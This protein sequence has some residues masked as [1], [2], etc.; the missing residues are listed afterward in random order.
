MN[1]PV[2]TTKPPAPASSPPDKGPH[3]TPL[4]NRQ[5]VKT[6]LLDLAKSKRAHKWTRVSETTL[7]TINELVRAWCVHHV[8]RMPSKG[9]TL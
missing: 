1:E 2:V 5:H 4:I 8:A 7:L 6:Y 3:R 9:Q